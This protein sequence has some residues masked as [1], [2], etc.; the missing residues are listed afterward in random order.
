MFHLAFTDQPKIV[1]YRS[2][3]E[4]DGARYRKLAD[5]LLAAGIRVLDRGL[6]YLS[7]AHEQRDIAFTLDQLE[8]VWD[9]VV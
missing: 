1:D 2:H 8:S 9:Q 4:S 6:W 7:A 5:L 3:L